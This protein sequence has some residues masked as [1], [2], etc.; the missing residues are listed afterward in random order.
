MDCGYRYRAAVGSLFSVQGIAVVI[1]VV[2]Q[3]S[4]VSIDWSMGY[5]DGWIVHTSVNGGQLT[6]GVVVVVANEIPGAANGGNGIGN[7]HH[8]GNYEQE[9]FLCLRKGK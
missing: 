2:Q 6:S 3:G 7:S 8:A 5:S 9:E 1:A 4:S